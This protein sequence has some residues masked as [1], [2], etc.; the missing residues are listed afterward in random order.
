[1]VDWLNKCIAVVVEAA[2]S[3]SLGWEIE[4]IIKMVPPTCVL[5]ICPHTDSEYQ[6]FSDAYK[7]LFPKR[8]PDFRPRE[9]LI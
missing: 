1:M 9:T 8:L 4:Q 5:I 3:A 2:D 7:N 6:S